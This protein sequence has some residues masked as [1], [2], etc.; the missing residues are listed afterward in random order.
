[1]ITI[2]LIS[3]NWAPFYWNLTRL[4]SAAIQSWTQSLLF[5]PFSSSTVIL[6]QIFQ[7]RA[8]AF[9]CSLKL[10][11]AFPVR[12][13]IKDQVLQS[14]TTVEQNYIEVYTAGSQENSPDTIWCMVG[15]QLE[16]TK[17]GWL[18]SP[19]SISTLPVKC[20]LLTKGV[21]EKGVVITRQVQPQG[22]LFTLS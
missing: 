20:L 21:R 10:E 11:S 8:R 14:D 4:V 18:F 17:A 15:F 16:R 22:S 3:A 1:M 19:H 5:Q 12:M 13:V 9:K 7:E 6:L 2:W